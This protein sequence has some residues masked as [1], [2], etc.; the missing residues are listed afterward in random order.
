MELRGNRGD[1]KAEAGQKVD[2]K[3]EEPPDNFREISIFPTV[4]DISNK[5][6]FLR[7]NIVGGSYRDVNTYLDVQ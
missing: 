2:I 4:R 7:K 6:P 1:G 5:K 3:D